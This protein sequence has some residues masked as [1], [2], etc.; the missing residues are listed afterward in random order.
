MED[1]QEEEEGD[2]KIKRED[3]DEEEDE[4]TGT[5]KQP[6]HERNI[7]H[8]RQ[9]M[10]YTIYL[11]YLSTVDHLVPRLPSCE[12]VYELH[13]STDLKKHM[14]RRSCGLHGPPPAA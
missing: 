8:L 2:E 9:V 3:D 12:A 4:P 1:D 13:T 14:P 6:L 11:M 5:K 7:S 10:I